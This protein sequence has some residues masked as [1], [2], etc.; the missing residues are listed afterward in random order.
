[1]DKAHVV[2][3]DTIRVGS[4][5]LQRR[6]ALAKVTGVCGNVDYAV[7]PGGAMIAC[8]HKNGVKLVDPA[9]YA[10]NPKKYKGTQAEMYDELGSK[11]NVEKF[12]FTFASCAKPHLIAITDRFLN[13]TSIGHQNGLIHV[14]DTQGEKTKKIVVPRGGG[15]EARLVKGCDEHLVYFGSRFSDEVVIKDLKKLTQL[16]VVSR[17]GI[18]NIAHASKSHATAI[19]FSAIAGSKT[20]EVLIIEDTASFLNDLDRGLAKVLAKR[21]ARASSGSGSGSGSSS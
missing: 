7:A 10:A 2:H 9:A 5:E 12:S 17:R 1:M 6:K 11:L 19:L 16:S 15:G 4:G 20:N 13:A 21:L 3:K 14:H 18:T 8:V